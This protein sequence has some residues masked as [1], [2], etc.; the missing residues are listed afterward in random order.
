[1]SELSFIEQ[2]RRPGPEP[3]GGAAAA[4]T[5]IV[6]AALIEK[7]AGLESNRPRAS[8]RW[9]RILRRIKEMKKHTVFLLH[10][11]CRTYKGIVEARKAGAGARLDAAV[12]ESVDCSLNLMSAASEML[13]LVA[14][15][16]DN[17]RKYLIA[18]LQVASEILAAAYA[19]AY[20]IGLA[21]LACISAP[22][23]DEL[24]LRPANSL[25]KCSET[26]R[27][28]GQTLAERAAEGD[29]LTP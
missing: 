15:V 21:N 11:D 1:M 12:K 17:C 8:E 20:H 19:G 28:V 24:N 27:C 23:R 9:G 10:E 13:E 14:E 29:V 4:Y 2:L 3:G 7:V 22:K 25:K 6:A 16:G 26:F 18:D 5:A